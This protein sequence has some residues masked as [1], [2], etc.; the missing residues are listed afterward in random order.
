MSILNKE[1]VTSKDGMKLRK[2]AYANCVKK[3]K[4][5]GFSE[6]DARILCGKML[7]QTTDPNIKEAKYLPTEFPLDLL[8][9]KPSMLY[10][11]EEILELLDSKTVSEYISCCME[12][13]KDYGKD[14]CIA[15][16]MELKREGK[17]TDD[18][19][20][21]S[22]FEIKKKKK[23][24]PG[25]EE[26][27]EPEEKIVKMKEPQE[28]RIT[29]GK[30][31]MMMPPE[32]PLRSFKSPHRFTLFKKLQTEE[33]IWKT[34]E[35][36]QS[37]ASYARMVKKKEIQGKDLPHV[38]LPYSFV[39]DANLGKFTIS[40]IR[41]NKGKFAGKVLVSNVVLAREMIQL[42]KDEYNPYLVRSHFKSYEELEKSIKGLD[43]LVTTIEH[44]PSFED[45]IKKIPMGCVRNIHADPKDR[46]IKGKVY[47]LA[48]KLSEETIQDIVDGKIIGVSIGFMANIDGP[49]VFKDKHYDHAQ[50]DF[51]YDHLA[52]C[53]KSI[54]R[55]PPGQC[56]I[57]I[58]SEDSEEIPVYT[59]ISNQDNY[60]NIEIEETRLK[61]INNEIKKSV[62]MEDGKFEPEDLKALIA[63]LRAFLQNL[64]IEERK[65]AL[66]PLFK[67][68]KKSD[69]KMDEE[70]KKA[71]EMKDSTIKELTEKLEKEKNLNAV[72]VKQLRDSSIKEI[73]K[74]GKHE[75]S[76]LEK[77]NLKILKATEDALKRFAPK[78]AKDAIV[79][80][81]LEDKDKPEEGKPKRID[82]R[83]IFQDTT[84]NFKM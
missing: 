48:D 84:K 31:S 40:Q 82:P 68:I 53:L 66:Q 37:R 38:E 23:K 6:G 8:R 62:D 58:D 76:E 5:A 52:I 67:S 74:F 32:A 81:K 28:K 59:F 16:A 72:I 10:D 27:E 50:R 20:D 24:K 75:D 11:A 25:E 46:S 60:S 64:S 21:P 49:G 18:I 70:S 45:W 56:G 57:N 9:N 79:L 55:C 14:K 35:E 44:P 54:P 42:Y 41:D 4:N 13:H 7:V 3:L 69:V 77:M 12:K 78:P 29:K 47:L 39:C 1:E 30:K 43:M 2:G 63:R 71:I 80:P 22:A 51:Q 15:I 33:Q 83:T 17:L 34:Q 36:L 61:N 73:K 26:E 65:A 19:G